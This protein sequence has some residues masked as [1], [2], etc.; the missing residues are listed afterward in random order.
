MPLTLSE[1]KQRANRAVSEAGFHPGFPPDVLREVSSAKPAGPLASSTEA[2]DLRSLLWS[3]IDNDESRD[4]DQVEYVEKSPD[5]TI[6]LLVGIADVDSSVT[7]GSAIDRRAAAES[8]SVYT[9]VETFPMLPPE[10]S[11]ERTSLLQEQD[12]LVLITEVRIVPSG[13]AEYHEV[14]PAWLRNAAKL[15]YSTTGAW[16]EGGA[17]VPSAISKAPGMEAQL[18]L[19]QETSEKLRG[20]RKQHGALAFNSVEATPVLENGEVKAL[21]VRQHNPA[22]DIIESF[23]VAANVA[24]AKYLR[25]H[26]RVS[27]RR[28]VKT[29]QR[30]DRIQAVAEQ[31]GTKLPDT[32]DPRALSNFLAAR[33]AADPLHFPDLSLAIVKL[34][35]P[36]EYVV[37]APGT[38]KEGHFGL[39]VTDY[40]HSTAPNRRYAD[41]ITQRLLKA[42]AADGA[43]PYSPAE[44]ALIAAHCTDREDAAR[45]VERLM[46]KVVAASLLS[47]RVGEVFDGIVTGAS[48]K[49]TYVRLLAFPAEGR[50]IR[51]TQGIDVGDKL[52]VRLASVEV[53]KGF[54][55]FERG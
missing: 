43:S 24:I 6:R 18:R 33:Q 45:K 28:V 2:R 44:L 19:Q 16:L 37:E 53:D 48:Q 4:L 38:E 52:R 55:D 50:L 36:G 12:R 13:E 34:L 25:D 47:Q 21:A 10:L 3:S 49:G 32:P 39:A 27:I 7:K 29:P 1:L 40:T 46:R 23:M 42:A 15:A 14:Y 5:G 54:I 17:P 9:G 11:T 26:Q 51:G 31:H 20:V 30:W 22:E 8:T 35:G 41:L